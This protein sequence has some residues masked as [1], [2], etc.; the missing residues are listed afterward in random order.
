MELISEIKEFYVIKDGN[1]LYIR[2]SNDGG[3]TFTS[4]EGLDIGKYQGI[5]VTNIKDVTLSPELFTWSEREGIY[6][7]DVEPS[8]PYTGLQWADTSVVPAV[9]KVYSGTDWIDVGNYSND[10]EQIKSVVK[11]NTSEIIQNKDYIE[12]L[13]EETTVTVDGNDISIKEYAESLRAD[14]DGL[15]N[16]LTVREGNNLIRDSIGCFNDG[17]WTGDYNLDSTNEVRALNQYG[18][19]L[20]L[21]NSTISQ[22]INVANGTYTLS[23]K[24]KKHINLAIAKLKIN[25]VEFVLSNNEITD[26]IYTFEVTSGIVELSF[27]AD[28][29]D[30]CTVINL[31]LNK[32]IE[33]LEWSFNQNE[34]WS[35]TVK[36]GR[37]V[38]ISSSGTDVQFVAYAD[39]IGFVDKNGNYITTFDKSG[40][41]T[42]EI[43]VKNKA[44]I[45]KLLIQDING[46]TT[47]NRIEE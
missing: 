11:S 35:D 33:K 25:D 20:L 12:G 36:I 14:L 18:Y 3:T 13:I 44:T 6:S 39:I 26:F 47:I 28:T 4:N 23:F 15:T 10:L 24:Y 22:N 2:Y 32:G 9:L 19:A 31:M 5:Y 7:S 27:T 42:D 34:T 43:V 16:T 41:I 1:Y 30:S 17:S 40:M 21:K 46:Q 8:N 38:R 45:V 29:D 37:G